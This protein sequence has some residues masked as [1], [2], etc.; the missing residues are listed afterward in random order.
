MLELVDRHDSGSC[1]SNGV[2]VRLSPGAPLIFKTMKKEGIYKIEDLAHLSKAD[3]HIHSNFSDG[4]PTVEEILLY[5]QNKTDLDVIA[6]TDHDTIEGALIGE[7]I[8][9]E[10]NYRFDV[11][12]GE[13]ITTLEGHIL[14]LFL[15]RPIEAGLSAKE[16]IKRIHVQGGLAVAAHPFEH[17]RFRNPD[18][19]IMDG[20]GLVSL[21]K[22]RKIIDAI[23]TVNGTPTLGGENYRAD[24]INKMIAFRAEAG[25]SDAHIL[26]AIGKGYTLFEGKTAI[27]LKNAIKKHQTQAMYSKWTFSALMRY[28]FF[29]IPKGLRMIFYTI[30]HGRTD[31]RPWL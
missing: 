6:I 10:Q 27:D 14:G 12:V 9:R 19:P 16:T 28:L 11:I 30:A 7:K 4:R 22:E 21:L 8:A 26:E 1:A 24:F 5:V 17:T 20:I 3:L 2:G 18:Q 23:E 29:F 31:E 13:E 25:S 15:V